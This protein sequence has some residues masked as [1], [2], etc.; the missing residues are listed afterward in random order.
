MFEL[1]PSFVE[2]IEGITLIA[3]LKINWKILIF[4]IGIEFTSS[5][6][7]YLTLLL[8]KKFQV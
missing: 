6:S 4:I 2:V 3:H 1:W 5:L 8:K 7:D